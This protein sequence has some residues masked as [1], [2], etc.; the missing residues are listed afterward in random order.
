MHE[1]VWLRRA[2]KCFLLLHH[3]CEAQVM[4]QQQE[5]RHASATREHAR[6][7]E[8]KGVQTLSKS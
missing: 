2:K 6:E 7:A 5:K 3:L 8:Q 1:L 4:Q